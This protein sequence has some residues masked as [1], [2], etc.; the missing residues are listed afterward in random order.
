MSSYLREAPDELRLPIRPSSVA[1]R[2]PPERVGRASLVLEVED[3]QAHRG[4]LSSAFAAPG[5]EVT[6]RTVKL[7][8]T[9][10]M[11]FDGLDPAFGLVNGMVVVD[12]F[13]LVDGLKAESASALVTV[14]G[15][16]YR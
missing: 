7:D 3:P 16:V 11:D 15:M 6:L 9:F 2:N 13:A 12:S 14:R 10:L 5:S 8:V 4:G 1:E